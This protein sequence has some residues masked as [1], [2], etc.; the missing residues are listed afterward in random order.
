MIYQY[1]IRYSPLNVKPPVAHF[2]RISPIRAAFFRPFFRTLMNA[3]FDKSSLLYKTNFIQSKYGQNRGFS[4]KNPIHNFLFNIY[5]FPLMGRDS[6]SDERPPAGKEPP[7]SSILPVTN[8][9]KY[10]RNPFASAFAK[11]FKK[12]KKTM[13]IQENICYNTSWLIMPVRLLPYRRPF[14]LCISIFG[15][16]R[17]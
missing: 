13:E 17:S 15:G 7:R 1:I 3:V 14:L 8:G 9:Q 2:S 16:I 10:C 6:G 12:S 4:S 11:I 5:I